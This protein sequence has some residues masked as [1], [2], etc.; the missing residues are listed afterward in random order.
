MHKL[1]NLTKVAIFSNKH[2]YK[3]ECKCLNLLTHPLV[4][5]LLHYK[6]RKFGQYGY[7]LNLLTYCIFLTFLN[8]FALIIENPRSQT[9]KLHVVP[10]LMVLKFFVIND[11][12]NLIIIMTI[13][14]LLSTNVTENG[15][16]CSK[17]LILVSFFFTK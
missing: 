13:G 3:V 8:I 5:S 12:S 6:W 2:I 15:I 1:N 10:K 16:D 9:C 14:L 4:G 7:L 11:S 17:A